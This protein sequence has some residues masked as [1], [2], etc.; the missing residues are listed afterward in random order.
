MSA[1]V[2]Q[3]AAEACRVDLANAPALL[4]GFT[5][6]SVHEP[7]SAISLIST[8]PMLKTQLL[9]SKLRDVCA[10]DGC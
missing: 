7:A 5:I 1:V 9:M 3:T 2:L 6:V 8:S 4:E 10:T